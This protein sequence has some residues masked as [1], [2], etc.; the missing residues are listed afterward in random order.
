MDSF[1]STSTVSI[2]IYFIKNGENLIFLRFKLF[3]EI[4]LGHTVQQLT[5]T[6]QSLHSVNSL[7]CHGHG[8]DCQSVNQ[9]TT[10]QARDLG[11]VSTTIQ[12]ESNQFIEYHCLS[13]YA[14]LKTQLQITA[15]QNVRSSEK[16]DTN[17]IL[18]QIIAIL[19]IDW[20]FQVVLLTSILETVS[21]DDMFNVLLIV[22]IEQ[23]RGVIYFASLL[24]YHSIQCHIANLRRGFSRHLV[25]ASCCNCRRVSQHQ[26]FVYDRY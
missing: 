12:L 20:T 8:M 3:R 15:S 22:W 6:V 2:D 10:G 26:V 9:V 7:V 16:P 18:H 11:H 5:G 13:R 23:K 21:S 1:N 19:V 17:K 4:V 24:Q 25:A 14:H